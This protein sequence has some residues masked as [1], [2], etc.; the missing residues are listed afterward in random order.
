MKAI[1]TLT[2]ASLL[3]VGGAAVAGSGSEEGGDMPRFD[4]MDDNSN[5]K[6]SMKEAKDHPSVA[7]RFEQLD[8]N[9][10]GVLSRQEVS[11]SGA[12]G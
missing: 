6:V 7:K 5:G 2:L 3:V 8:A 9:G 4:R 1:G 10:N 11:G 12:S